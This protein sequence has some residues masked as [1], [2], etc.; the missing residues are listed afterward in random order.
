MALLP[1]AGWAAN[2]GTDGSAVVDDIPYGTDVAVNNI[3]FTLNGIEQEPGSGVYKWEGKYYTNAT[4]TEELSGKPQAGVKYWIKVVPNNALNNGECIAEI[5]FTKADLTLK[6]KDQAFFTKFFLGQTTALPANLTVAASGTPDV[7]VDGLKNDDTPASVLS[8]SNVSFDYGTNEDANADNAGNWLTDAKKNAKK[9]TFS[10]FTLTSASYNLKFEDRFMMIKQLQLDV[11]DFAAAAAVGK[12]T[13][14]RSES[15]DPANK[16]VYTGVKQ[17]LAYTVEYKYGAGENDVYTFAAGDYAIQY[18]NA[19]TTYNNAVDALAYTPVLW[20]KASGNF[21]EEIINLATSGEYDNDKLGYEIEKKSLYVLLNTNSKTYDGTI[22]LANAAAQPDPTFN[23]SSLVGKDAGK[24]VT[25][26]TYESLKANTG[27]TLKKD[28]GTYSITFK[29]DAFDGAAVKIQMAPAPT[30]TAATAKIYNA[31]LPGAKAAGDQLTTTEVAAF[32]VADAESAAGVTVHTVLTQA[33]ADA[34][35]ATLAGAK[36]AGNGAALVDITNNYEP[37]GVA[38]NWTINKQAITVTA[39]PTYAPGATSI[40]FGADIPAITIS[41][42]NALAG[43]ADAVLS[44]YKATTALKTDLVV[45]DNVITVARKT[46][47]DYVAE[48]K[49]AN[50]GHSDAEANT[51]ATAALNAANAL[52]ANYEP[53]VTPGVLKVAGVGLTIIP[54]VAA[55]TEYGTAIAPAY[56]AFNSNNHVPVELAKTPT[57]LYRLS[58]EAAS[59]AT[60]TVPT[61]VGS[62]VVSIKADGELAPVNGYDPEK[63]TYE[64]TPFEITP[65]T[66]H[67]TVANQTVIK[68]DSKEVFL[69]KL[70]N[71]ETSWSLAA[72]ETTV[73]DETLTLEFSLNEYHATSNPAGTVVVTDGK[74]ISKAE[75]VVLDANG[76]IGNAIMVKLVGDYAGNYDI[77]GYTVGKLKINDAYVAD[78]NKINAVEVI[79]DAAANGNNYDVTLT[80][81]GFVL[82]KDQ[83]STLVLPFAIDPLKFCE[84]VGT[85]AVFNELKSATDGNVKFGLTYSELPANTPFLVKPQKD[86]DFGKVNNNN[87]PA[88]PADDYREIIFHGVKFENTNVDAAEKTATATVGEADFIGVYDQTT[89]NGAAGIYIPQNGKFHEVATG[90]AQVYFMAAYLKVNSANA[91]RITVEEADGSTTAISAITADGQLIPAEGWYTLN[92]VK[93]Q[94]APVEKGVYI[95]NGKKVVIK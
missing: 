23:F 18:K 60:T 94:A 81:D 58:T 38:A 84:E 85:Y 59:A 76:F 83:W 67:L 37:V 95:N 61:A 43:E 72:N 34:Y 20:L 89:V 12:F 47:A 9:I 71:S 41:Q 90:T 68:N 22:F 82:K 65:K 35:N 27:V 66:L 2:F 13:V 69:T 16:P 11:D 17:N 64:E 63:I 42:V 3:H 33:Q 25:G 24:P 56:A 29:D 1:L 93:L 26:L 4:A 87:T 52:M 19:G 7:L 49:A 44:A 55:A 54:N 40:T 74:I 88:D 73:N 10:G 36:A 86:I 14:T 48:D 75:A 30:Y 79:T 21:E 45:G 78:L 57:Y 62:Y 5:I 31:T 8:W 77:T 53:T 51:A 15:Y 91:A 70:A 46:K 92:G 28:Q 32:T 80:D 6:V 50:P 39:T